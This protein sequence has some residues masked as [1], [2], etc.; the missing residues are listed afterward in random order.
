MKQTRCELL[1]PGN[2]YTLAGDGFEEESVESTF[3][4]KNL[5]RDAYSS[6]SCFDNLGTRFAR[7]DAELTR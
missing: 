7:I 6:R 4:E 5:H 3:G 2:L 1:R